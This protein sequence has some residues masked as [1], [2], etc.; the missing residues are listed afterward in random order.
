MCGSRKC[1]SCACRCSHA[2]Q[3]LL[4]LKSAEL[5]SGALHRAMEGVRQGRL[6]PSATV[7]QGTLTS[8]LGGVSGCD[9]D[10]S[11][12]QWSGS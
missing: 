5:L 4:Y 1:S 7:K 3:L 9:A 10:A 12:L 11:L 6:Y 2:E 8:C